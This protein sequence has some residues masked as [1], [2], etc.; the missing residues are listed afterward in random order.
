MKPLSASLRL[1]AICFPLAVIG[2]PAWTQTYPSRPITLIVPFP[3]GAVTDTQARIMSERMAK[4]LGQPIV[5]ENITGAGGTIGTERV[6]RSSN[7][8]YTIGIGQWT[9]HVSAPSMFPV[10]Y[11]VLTDLEPIARL[12]ASPLWIALRAG[13]PA[14]DLQSLMAWLK[15]NPAKATAALPAPGSGGHIA[16][17]HLQSLT[18]TRFQ[19]V[20]YRGGAPAMQ[21]LLAGHVDMMCGE[22]SQMLA[23]VRD[24]RLKAIAVLAERRWPAAPEV[25]TIDEAGLPGL[26]ISFWHGL[27]APK[28]TPPEIIARLNAAVVESLADAAVQQKFAALGQEMPG[29]EQQMPEALRSHHRGEVERWWPI[30]KA[31]E[32]KAQ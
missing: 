20:P 4:S 18:G 15:A 11:D 32:V 27:W 12:P 23:S 22:A 7:D 13:F 26:H 17:L 28:A 5:V 3:A 19:L 9:S 21:D 31:A 6:V 8:G 16:F 29:R 1:L 2:T 30:I 24:G 25:P 10:K 14:T